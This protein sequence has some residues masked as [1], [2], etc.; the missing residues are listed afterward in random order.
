MANDGYIK[1]CKVYNNTLKRALFRS[2][3]QGYNQDWNFSWEMWNVQGLEMYGNTFQGVIDFA[4][5]TKG[6][7]SYGLWFHDNI[8]TYPSIS[9]YYQGGLQLETNASDIIIDNNHFSNMMQC[10][11]FSPFDYQGNGYGIDV[12]RV[13]ISRNLMDGI[14]YLTPLIGGGNLIAVVF[15]NCDAQVSYV[16]NIDFFNN[17]MICAQQTDWYIGIRL[18]T[19][20]GGHCKNVRVINNHIEGFLSNPV[21]LNPSELLNNVEV[22]N[23]NF[24]NNAN[25]TVHFSGAPPPNYSEANNISVNPLFMGGGNYTLQN[26]SPLIDKGLNV[27]LTYFGNTP[28]IGYHET[29]GTAVFPPTANAGIDQTITLPTTTTTLLGSGSD[30]DGTITAYHWTKISGPAAGNITNASAD[31]TPVTGLVLGTYQFELKVTDNNGAVGKDTVKVTVNPNPFNIAPTANAGADQTITLPTNTITVTGSGTDPDGTITTYLWSKIAGP[32]SGSITNANTASTTITAL[33][34]G[35]YQFE[36]RVTDDNGSFGR[37]TVMI[38][39]NPD[40]NI[41]PTANAGAD[42]TITLP[43]NSGTLTGSG[44]DADGTIA[45]YHWTKIAGPNAGTITNTASA[46]TTVTGLVSGIYKFELR[47]TDNNGAFGRDTVMITVN[48]DPNIAPVANAGA[49]QSITFPTNTITL[50]GSGTDADGTITAYH[51]AKISGPNAGT[52]TNAASATTTVTGLVGGIYKFELTVTDNNGAVGRDNMQLIVY[53][54]N[55][56]PTANAGLNQ[57]L[58]LPTNTI[59][60]NGSGTDVDGIIV[61]YLWT[62]LAGPT[63]GAITSPTAARTTITGLTAGVYYFVLRVTDNNGAFGS[64]TMQINVSPE[65]I[66]PVAHAGADQTITLPNKKVTLNGSGTDIDGTVVSYAWKQIAGPAD[67]LTSLY[68]PATVIDD[69][70]E[71]SYKFE[72]TVTDNKGAKGKDTVGVIVEPLKVSTPLNT[73]KVYPNPVVDMATLEIHKDNV[74]A[75][76]LVVITDMQGKI[77]LQKQVVPAAVI[78]RQPLDF[79][80]LSKGAYLVTVYFSASEK[81]T[82]KIIKL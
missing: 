72:L 65:N 66:A 71:G 25:N 70:I 40:P 14:G 47:V 32:N 6:N 63:G 7:Y 12:H 50:T 23:N 28:D 17:T 24:Y 42:Q 77:V 34:Q 69:M 21:W 1:G 43:T 46:I 19:Y 58:T 61:A 44:T 39:V 30:S 82:E 8:I 74:N 11:E 81:Q 80:R 36:L 29:G 78:T 27:G 49:D 9:Q 35:V 68:T 37:D 16:D 22:K 26:N 67:K 20:L 53:V 2:N 52:I 75:T 64:D 38:T 56:P 55:I 33:T 48:P 3:Q 4:N 5:V 10:I 51:W 13:T 59:A 73:I 76:M 57:S 41:A 15:D 31:T 45:A 79:T 18:P 60:L 62:K 54:P